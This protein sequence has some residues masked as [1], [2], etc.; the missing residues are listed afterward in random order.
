MVRQK[1]LITGASGFIGSHLCRRL[2]MNAAEIHAISRIKRASADG[3]SWWQGD[4]ADGKT[5]HSLVSAIR[6]DII[7][8]LAS[9]VEGSRDLALVIPTFQSNLASTVNLLQA[10]AE[11]GS[12]R[13]ILCGSLEEP[14]I[15]SAQAT[16]SSPYAA[17]KWAS[18]AYARMFHALYGAEVIILRI[19]MVY[20]PAQ[21]DLRK[22][23]PYVI[24]SFLRG[25]APKLSSGQRPI[26][27]IYVED[28]VEA[29]VT[30]ARATNVEGRTLEIGSGQLV[31]IRA[32]VEEIVRLIKPNTEPLFGNLADRPLEQ[33]RAANT[34]ET[35]A[36]I[37]WKSMI[38]LNEGLERTVHWFRER[39]G[40]EIQHLADHQNWNNELLK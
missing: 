8:H 38:S 29:L 28:V 1:I 33:V 30:T 23:I 21:Q 6:P 22:V 35:A 37:G 10:A 2:R 18:S 17:A 24:S 13:M 19:F 12:C 7:F 14:S 34:A 3:I 15:E 26:D 39:L 16:P 27:W 4:L 36:L 11:L 20:G 31:T 40:S 32:V 9:H 5:A 25:E